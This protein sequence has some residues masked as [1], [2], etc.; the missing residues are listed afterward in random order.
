M[1][2]GGPSRIDISAVRRFA[3]RAAVRTADTVDVVAREIESR[4]IER[5]AMVK[6]TPKRILEAGSGRFPAFAP[7]RARY[8]DAE[9]IAMDIASHAI[10]AGI[11]ERT[12]AE[13][14]RQLFTSSR[15]HAV[16]GDFSRLPIAPG[17]IDF[18]WSNLALGA[19][20]EDGLF[21]EWHRVLATGGLVM[22]S[23]FGPDTLMEL[24]AAF[25]VS[26]EPARV[27]TFVD[28][29]DLGDQLVGAGFADP[30]ME[31]ERLT[32]TYASVEQLFADLRDTGQANAIAVRRRGLTGKA[33]WRAALDRLEAMRRDGRLPVTVEVVYGHAWKTVPKKTADGSA[34]MRFHASAPG[35]TRGGG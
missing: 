13:R 25:A 21:D 24:R 32:L 2:T 19:R 8:R 3:N 16:C 26:G 22:F 20:T 33:G 15:T 12:L 34:I 5:L 29:H 9:V 30:V 31:M 11:R 35:A 27:H 23:A 7:L 6:L 28:M 10:A 14:V 18:I 4:M 1:D 17:S